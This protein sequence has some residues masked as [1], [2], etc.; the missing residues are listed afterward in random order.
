MDEPILT[1]EI[2]A[3][4]CALRKQPDKMAQVMAILLDEEKVVA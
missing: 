3:L 4:L 2:M 1:E